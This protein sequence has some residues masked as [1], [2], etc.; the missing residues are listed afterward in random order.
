MRK[1]VS[2]SL[3]GAFAFAVCGG[4]SA[5]PKTFGEKAEQDMTGPFGLEMGQPKS[6]F[7]DLNELDF[8][9]YGTSEIG[10][11]NGLMDYYEMS[12]APSGLCMVAGVGR[13]IRSKRTGDE[14]RA[15]MDRI[16]SRLDLK[17]GQSE[18]SDELKAD[19]EL[20]DDK[21]WLESVGSGERDFRYCWFEDDNRTF[22]ANI[23]SIC[24]RANA[25]EE[26]NGYI[27]YVY[28]R[29]EFDNYGECLDMDAERGLDDL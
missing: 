9:Y 3:I 25:Y 19:S 29:Y 26:T 18:F 1:L 6:D 10:R 21:T 8:N 5:A 7:D 22:P 11:K 15:E 13:D 16:K 23:E 27:G 20:G 24:M 28:L 12:F 17:Y 14:L 2:L 4:S